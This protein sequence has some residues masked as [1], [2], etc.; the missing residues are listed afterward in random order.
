MLGNLAIFIVFLSV[1][2]SQRYGNGGQGFGSGFNRIMRFRNA[3][4]GKGGNRAQGGN[5]EASFWTA[6]IPG[7]VPDKVPKIPEQE[8]FIGWYESRA[9]GWI[10]STVETADIRSRP[11]MT[12]PGVDRNSLYTILMIDYGIKEL[13]GAQYFHW[14]ISN[15]PGNDVSQGTENME[16]IPPF[17]FQRNADNTGVVE[18][19]DAPLHDIYTLVYRQPG[20]INIEENQSGCSSDI[21][22]GR[23][24][25]KEALVKK[26]GLEGPVAGKF[27]WTKLSEAT[28]FWFCYYTRCTGQP[29]PFS[30][31]IPGR[32]DGPE[33]QATR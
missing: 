29:F 21:V 27:F 7:A 8:L 5:P 23:V 14:L 6:P 4:F 33:C 12:W 20:F 25:D 16:Y 11:K 30:N 1:T 31:P 17:G 18:T 3:F 32:N 22:R 26:Y 9:K 15:V 2:E 13:E 24:N 28:Y 19:G 10:N